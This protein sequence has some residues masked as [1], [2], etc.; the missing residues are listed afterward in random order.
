MPEVHRRLAYDL[1]RFWNDNDA[2]MQRVFW[3]FRIAAWA[4]VA[5]IAL[6]LASLSG[7]LSQRWPRAL[8]RRQLLRRRR[9]SVARRHEARGA[10]HG[11]AAVD[12]AANGGLLRLHY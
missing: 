11:R 4:L 3:G 5:E 2:T 12:D 7:T 1:E 6:L 8:H 9:E 10:E